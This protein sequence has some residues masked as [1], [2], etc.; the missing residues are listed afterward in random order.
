MRSFALLALLVAIASGAETL[1]LQPLTAPE[2]SSAYGIPLGGNSMSTWGTVG[3]AVTGTSYTYVVGSSA[4]GSDVGKNFYLRTTLY[5]CTQP[6]SWQFQ[7]KISGNDGTASAIH[8][9]TGEFSVKSPSTGFSTDGGNSVDGYT[10]GTNATVLIAVGADSTAKAATKT[11]TFNIALVGATAG[12][13]CSF[14]VDLITYGSQIG[15]SLVGKDGNPGPVQ[16]AWIPCCDGTQSAY[17]VSMTSQEH[18][19]LEV[20]ASTAAGRFT[21]LGLTNPGSLI[22]LVDVTSFPTSTNTGSVTARTC[23]S[24]Q[25]CAIVTDN[26]FVE[27][28]TLGYAYDAIDAKDFHA[29][30]TLTTKAGV[31]TA[32]ATIAVAVAAL[33]AL[34][35]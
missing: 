24:N 10:S 33:F 21:K 35:H 17:Q 27:L 14:F 23:L 1:N 8:F 34:F 9:T 5:S 3:S 13:T 4:A 25:S 26:Y 7:T 11:W 30:F 16:D 29:T 32:S 2:G 20:A 15:A 6:G 28:S 31:A 19:Y 12:T 18:K 22:G